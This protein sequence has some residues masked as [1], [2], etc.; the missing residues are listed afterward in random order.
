MVLSLNE[1]YNTITQQEPRR[2]PKRIPKKRMQTFKNTDADV[3]KQIAKELG[4]E[5]FGNSRKQR[6]GTTPAAQRNIEL[7]IQNEIKENFSNT[8][9]IDQYETVDKEIENFE[10]VPPTMEDIEKEAFQ[11]EEGFRRRRRRRRSRKRRPSRRSRRRS[12]K[13]KKK[14]R[15]PSRRSRRRSR[16]SNE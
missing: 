12:R 14:S 8:I 5:A 11:G 13:S 2:I 9:S 1:E 4:D 10:D 6:L 16:K 3:D 7:Q 15:R